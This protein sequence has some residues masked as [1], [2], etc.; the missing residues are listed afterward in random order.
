M[1]LSIHKY[2]IEVGHYVDNK[3]DIRYLMSFLFTKD[4][5]EI[6]TTTSLED[7]VGFVTLQAAGLIVRSINSSLPGYAASISTAASC[8][9]TEGMITKEE[10]LELIKRS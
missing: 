10:Y 9:V 8:A 1:N 5:I 6:T 2:V 4:G 7:S 3:R